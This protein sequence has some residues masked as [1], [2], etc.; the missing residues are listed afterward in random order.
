[1]PNIDPG[2]ENNK[3]FL[4]FLVFINT[5][6]YGLVIL[7][8]LVLLFNSIY[9]WM[10]TASIGYVANWYLDGLYI[11]EKWQRGAYWARKLSNRRIQWQDF[12]Y[13][14]K[15]SSIPYTALWPLV[16]Q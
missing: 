2:R 10:Q 8:H 9:F 15:F 16:C 1:M 14:S 12:F 7:C 3:K 11:H 5:K 13:K 6:V 4:C